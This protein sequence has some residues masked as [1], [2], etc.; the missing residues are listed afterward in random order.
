[1]KK[2]WSRLSETFYKQLETTQFGAQYSKGKTTFSVFAT[3]AERVRIELFDNPLDENPLIID[4]QGE[5][6]FYTIDIGGNLEGR[7]YQYRVRR[8]GKWILAQDP[9]AYSMTANSQLAMVVNF[10][11]TNPE[12]WNLHHK[13]K[14]ITRTEAVLY[15]THI[16]DSTVSKASNHKYPGKYIGM[17]EKNTHT[18][19]GLKTG[20]DHLTELGITHVHLL[21]LHDM[22]SVDEISGGYNWGYD[23]MYFM[24]PEGVYATDSVDGSVRVKEF[25]TMVKVFHEADIRVVLDV[26]YNH[27]FVHEEHPFEIL[28]PGWYFRKTADGTFGNGSGCGNETASESPL[29]QKYVLDSLRLY[30]ETYQVD[31]F[32]FDL[33]A[34]HDTAFVKCI[35]A[36]VKA[37]R[38]DAILYGEPWTGWVSLLPKS[39]QFKQGCQKGMAFALFNDH[40]RNAVKGDNDGVKKGF[41]SGGKNR[42]QAI[43]KGIAGGI[44]YNEILFDYAE[45]PGEVINYVSCHDNLCLYDKLKSCH[46]DELD[47]MLAKRSLMALSIPLLSFGTPFIQGG[48]EIMRTKYGDHNS[49]ISGDEINGI[50]WERKGEFLGHFE[51]VK[52]LIKLRK[53]FGC[54]AVDEDNWIRENLK[55][56]RLKSGVIAYEIVLS[57]LLK[58][59][60][61]GVKRILIVHNASMK[62]LKLSE[63]TGEAEGQLLYDS[64][65]FLSGKGTLE[66]L[67]I[68]EGEKIVS[69]SS[70][71]VG[72]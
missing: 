5:P 44:E 39:K 32:R 26:V 67:A 51:A 45:K 68:S 57:D 14:I 64:E 56:V 36:Q 4:M 70:V 38:P 69:M 61:N 30:L 12:G 15:E 59:L 65:W 25:K 24:A 42:E 22:G 35:E 72:L 60:K 46:P 52:A 63:L 10:E 33:L 53:D 49:F 71:I 54:F 66:V 20:L 21:P 28:A 8:G 34:L 1:M 47:E 11:S 58:D 41:V 7:Y 17:V 31:G 16:N 29:F 37:I 6:P 9:W 27:T 48:T 13:P 23:P 18:E 62:A 2:P 3:Q 55:F 19:D 50:Q 43:A 40:L